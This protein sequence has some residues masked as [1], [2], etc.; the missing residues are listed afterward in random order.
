MYQR[1][2]MRVSTRLLME[3]ARNSI[4]GGVDTRVCNASWYT[5]LAIL[6]RLLLRRSGRGNPFTTGTRLSVSSHQP[7]GSPSTIAAT[8][9]LRSQSTSLSIIG[10]LYHGTGNLAQST[11]TFFAMA[12]SFLLVASS[13]FTLERKSCRPSLVSGK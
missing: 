4:F 10:T 1:H 13:F 7:T 12:S 3:S 6:F 9:A 5:I 2:F 8:F 11:F